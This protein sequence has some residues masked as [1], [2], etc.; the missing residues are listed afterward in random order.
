MSRT[1][2]V[3]GFS[4]SE[5]TDGLSKERLD[6]VIEKMLTRESNEIKR[7][8]EK[9]KNIQTKMDLYNQL[10]TQ[11]TNYSTAAGALATPSTFSMVQSSSTNTLSA[12]FPTKSAI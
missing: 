11:L 4:F 2:S 3:G 9:Q 12:T 10:N 1:S 5:I 8:E 6:K 7:T